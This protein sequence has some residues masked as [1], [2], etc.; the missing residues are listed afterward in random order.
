[1]SL[2]LHFTLDEATRSQTATRL[3]IPNVPPAG[4]QDHMRATAAELEILRELLGY[5]KII[6]DSWYRCE[7]L[8]RAVGGAAT[9]AHLRGWAV[10]FIVPELGSPR[11]V[12]EEVQRLWIRPFD[13]LIYEGNWV[14][15]SFEPPGRKQ[16]LTAR[17]TSA[18]VSYEPGL[19]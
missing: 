19:V 18:G 1:M 10:D 7:A 3:C 13:Q 15:M 17:F 2:S 11:R 16:V 12:A 8:N 6:V 14:H 5:R 9:S 4:V